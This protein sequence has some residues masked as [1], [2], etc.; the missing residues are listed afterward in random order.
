MRRAVGEGPSLSVAKASRATHRRVSRDAAKSDPDDHRER[1]VVEGGINGLKRHRAVAARYVRPAVL[2]E[3][4][5]LFAA[6]NVWLCLC[7][8]P[9]HVCVPDVGIALGVV[10]K[11]SR[12]HQE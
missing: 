1:H 8:T 7:L 10:V 4:T 5:V 3:G 12:P 11:V 6:I 9:H 2:Y